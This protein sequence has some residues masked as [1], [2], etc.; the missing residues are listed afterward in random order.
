MGLLDSFARSLSG[1]DDDSYGSS[2]GNYGSYNSGGSAP[3]KKLY[4]CQRCGKRQSVS[5]PNMLETRVYGGNA[6]VHIWRELN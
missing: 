5:N 1:R 2:Y 3:Q 4:Q 6:C